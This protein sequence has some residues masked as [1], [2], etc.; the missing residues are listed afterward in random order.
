MKRA[1]TSDTMS[2]A[3]IEDRN[4]PSGSD[5]RCKCGKPSVGYGSLCDARMNARQPPYRTV[6]P[7]TEGQASEETVNKAV[8]CRGTASLMDVFFRNAAMNSKATRR[9]T[10]HG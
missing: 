4:D 6:R 3:A 2:T 8:R 9:T 5:F 1:M 10:V 7:D